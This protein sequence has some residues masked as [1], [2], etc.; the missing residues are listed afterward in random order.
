M[1]RRPKSID[2]L[3]ESLEERAKEL[4]C[5]YAVEEILQ[6]V[7]AD[8]DVILKNIVDIIP[9]AMQ[10]PE[11]CKVKIIYQDSVYMSTDFKATPW[12]I[13]E[14]ITAQDRVVG[15]IKAHYTEEKPA[16]DDG[17]FLKE[18]KRVLNTIAR[19]IGQFAMYQKMRQIYHQMDLTRKVITEHKADEWR[20]VL[21]LLRRSDPDVYTRISR[22]MLNHLI[23][24]GV[25]EAEQL[26]QE[27]VPLLRY[28]QQDY[29]SESNI[30][31]QKQAAED[32]VLLSQK[33]FDI[34]AQH[35][36]DDDILT[37]IQD[38]VKQDKTSFL[39]RAA[40]SI[41]SSLPEVMDA[42]RRYYKITP[43]GLQLA[44][45]ARIGVRAGLIRR[46]FTDQLEFVNI[47]KN[48]VRI[49]DFYDM[50]QCLIC[51]SGSHGKLGGKSAGLFL[52]RRILEA[53]EEQQEILRDIKVP[54]SWYI[55]SDAMLLFMHYN[56][57]EELL[58][59][60]YKPIDEI[61][62]E[63][64]HVVM[65]FKNSN[66]PPEIVQGLSMALDDF[67]DKPLIVR[68]S[69]LLE[70]RLGSAFSGKY[71]SLFLA[72]QGTKNE[73]LE[74][75]LDAIAEVYAST[76]GPDPMQYRAE[77]GLLDFHEEM[78][79]MIQ[80]VVGK[81]VGKYYL[82]AFA[83]VAFSNN[84]FRW[85]P[86]IKRE[87]GLIR[88]VPGLGTRAVDRLSDD[89][90]IL[91]APGQPELRANARI[92]DRI[93]YSPQKIDV[94]NLQSNQFESIEVLDLLREYGDEFPMVEQIISIN[95]QN[96]LRQPIGLTI[97]FE[98]E[99]PIITFEGLI[100]N[101]KFIQ[102]VYNILKTLQ[103]A[104]ATPVDIEFAS[105]GTDF[106][107]LQCRPQSY[108]KY[109][110][111]SQIPKNL[112]ANQVL[113]TA[114]RF[115]SN[116][117][118]PDI[119]FIV[120]V[121]PEHY[122]RIQEINELKLVGRIVGKLN[123]ILPR[124]QFI[125]M[126]PGRWGSRG[127]IKLG[128]NVTYSDINNTAVLIE[129]AR[130]KGNYVP[131]LSFGTHFFQD[132]VEAGI[133]YLPLYPDDDEVAF[134]DEFLSKSPNALFE[135]FPA[136]T[137]LS[138]TIRV[139]DVSAV[140]D[141]RVLRILMNAD[142]E[143]AVGML[144]P[145]SASPV[146][147]VEFEDQ[148]PRKSDDHWRWR[149]SMVE[150]MAAQLHGEQYGVRGLYVIGSTVNCTAQAG[151]DIDLLVSF[152]G[153]EEQKEQLSKWLMGWSLCLDEFN[154]LRTGYKAGGLLDLHF[155]SDMDLED[156][157]SLESRLNV[158]TDN[159]RELMLA[160]RLKENSESEVGN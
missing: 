137:H 4:N 19:R 156:L 2:K 42:I 30:P 135:I 1:T 113:F 123:Q 66:F 120:Y 36:S 124:R 37:M 94:L 130:K 9:S 127:D 151:S 52:A 118:V 82:P 70:D 28:G 45:S 145:K 21:D 60:K 148:L 62:K 24:R 129:I 43:E 26:L 29:A 77:R 71:K 121:D 44:P 99:D 85:S 14:E 35:L 132:L 136:Y 115:I 47:A 61:R 16:A 89:Y 31:L 154:F 143:K 107:L 86:R 95:E 74:A 76:L 93:R 134:N 105:N 87:D 131:D 80:E 158:K 5:L 65:L 18:E 78:G 114:N 10:F 55:S 83:G 104:L 159:I 12:S 75:L 138:D 139:I 97:D 112:P 8:L 110:A 58:E 144:S 51:P 128:V 25:G 103:N 38:W 3:I 64:P 81:R 150:K 98:K 69:S 67:E 122:S 102:Q 40:S 142:L 100:R 56:N 133:R 111:P 27:F 49:S 91:V 6:D 88:L 15:W 101:T 72:N 84:E 54:K 63:Y 32:S 20:A 153:S 92:E 33:V 96:H 48:F 23:W 157:D 147:Q 7:S 160:D 39:V 141:G 50:I 53:N 108:T 106:Y 68:S 13:S 41:N 11:V 57:L 126:G 116:G 109:D 149:L 22:K 73:R 117:T 90:P 140:A 17:P 146:A 152:S 79:I 119:R 59:Q 125:L 34:A 155:V 46:F